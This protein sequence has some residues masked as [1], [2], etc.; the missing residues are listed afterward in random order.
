LAG[1]MVTIA[2]C[3]ASIVTSNQRAWTDAVQEARRPDLRAHHHRRHEA[4]DL[5]LISDQAPGARV[6]LEDHA[7]ADVTSRLLL[8]S[9]SSFLK[10]CRTGLEKFAQDS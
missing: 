8:F 5:L 6:D 1:V 10:I 2:G 3:P 4:G 7:D 9:R